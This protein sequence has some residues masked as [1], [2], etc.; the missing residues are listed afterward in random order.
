MTGKHVAQLLLTV[1]FLGT[2]NVV[3]SDPVQKNVE[4]VGCTAEKLRF[5]PTGDPEA[6]AE[7]MKELYDKAMAIQ[8]KSIAERHARHLLEM[9]FW[10]G[11]RIGPARGVAEE[12]LPLYQ[13]ICN[14][15]GDDL[16]YAK[17]RADEF[18]CWFAPDGN[19]RCV[20]YGAT[21]MRVVAN[22]NGWKVELHVRP[23]LMSKR[24]GIPFT[25]HMVI[26]TWQVNKNGS[27]ENLTC[28]V[29]DAKARGPGGL[30]RD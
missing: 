19:D 22:E 30:M 12:D 2:V 8:Q 14:Q 27:L 15:F 5:I 7:Q 28:V 18:S 20:G 13:W 17:V 9:E 16:P 6:D 4:C 24:G 29:D 10:H 3:D 21:L 25:A 1:G 26:E 11:T 23:R